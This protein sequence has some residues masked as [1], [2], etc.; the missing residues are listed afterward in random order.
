MSPLKSCD[1][2]NHDAFPKVGLFELLFII[3]F[4]IIKN[5]VVFFLFV[6]FVAIVKSLNVLNCFRNR[7]FHR[8]NVQVIFF[9][10]VFQQ[11]WSFQ[12]SAG[13]AQTCVCAPVLPAAFPIFPSP[14]E[15]PH[16]LRGAL[17]WAPGGGYTA[18]A[19]EQIG[20]LASQTVKL[21]A[22]FCVNAPLLR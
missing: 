12:Q 3:I 14:W 19:L 22:N 11:K 13:P 21:L 7:E 4:L 5:N 2:F 17:P 8:K 20:F 15:R 18:R 10:A 1:H 9:L 6:L 16:D